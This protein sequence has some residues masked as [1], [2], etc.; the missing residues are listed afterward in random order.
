MSIAALAP[1]VPDGYTYDVARRDPRAPG[2]LGDPASGGPIRPPRRWLRR[3]LWSLAFTAV[4]LIAL[5]VWVLAIGPMGF[6][7]SLVA[8]TAALVPV[9]IVLSAVW[10][11]D[12]YTPQPRVALSF[13]FA[14]GAAV[15]VALALLIGTV[16]EVAIASSGA[17]ENA[18]Q[19]LGA[20]VQAPIVE[21]SMKSAGLLALLIMGR[22]F[23]AG[24]LDGVVHAM[25]IAGGFAFTENV[26]YFGQAFLQS[27]AA[28]EV[29]A[30]WQTFLLRGVMSPFAHAG[31]TSL[32]GLGLGLAAARRSPLLGV[33]LGIG[34]L[35]L[36][37]CLHALWNGATFFIDIDP[38]APLRSFLT[39]YATVQ[40]PIFL[41]LAGILL[42]LRLRERRIVRRH[43]SEYS[44][45]G[46]FTPDEIA[47]VLSLRRRRRAER[48]AARSGAIPR[49]AVRDFIRASVQLAMDRS[50]VTLSRSTPRTRREE[51]ELL[52]RITADRR[53]VGALA[54]P[55]V[56]P[57]RAG[58]SA[59]A[60]DLPVER[61]S[62]VPA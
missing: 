50:S 24:P 2:A 49:M 34:G 57:R 10:W 25:M 8:L 9:S 38:D 14:W 47:M 62:T 33:G 31:F 30:F 3:L 11:L 28:G 1:S 17:Q 39:Y 7:T 54:H 6:G 15:S 19:F 26:L 18:A 44:R 29:D 21:E 20:V 53:V 40:L 48:L 41:V 55:V 56:R 13:S 36:G 43:L 16:A 27:Q 59:A 46:W 45:A 60:R 42:W 35:S 12:R 58:G 37:M 32:A 61:T 22:R 51:R 23:I 52:E 4:A 5:G